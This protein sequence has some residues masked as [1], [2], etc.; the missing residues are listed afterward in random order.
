MKPKIILCLALVLSGVLFGCATKPDAIDRL[1]NS[2]SSSHGLW[3]N[4]LSPVIELP[5]TASTEE[6][7]SKVLARQA[8]SY[9]ILKVRYVHIQGSLPDL[10]TAVIV[11]TDVGEKIVLFKYEGQAVG[12]WSR[13]YDAKTSSNR[14]IELGYGRSPGI[15]PGGNP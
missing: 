13:I 14:K 12:W 4:G 1:V 11:E 3:Q 9:K 5:A 15:F 7:V 10:Y 2:L 8:T 6:V